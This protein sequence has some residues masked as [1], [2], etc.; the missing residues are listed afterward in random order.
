M[1]SDWPAQSKTCADRGGVAD[2]PEDLMRSGAQC[3]VE[4]D[5][6]PDF[7]TDGACAVLH[8]RPSYACPPPLVRGL[9]G[10]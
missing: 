2:L 4:Y 7:G 8:R 1:G 9:G 5:A 6:M 3:W 10:S